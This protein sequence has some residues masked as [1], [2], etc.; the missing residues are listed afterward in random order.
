MQTTQENASQL[1]K[2]LDL[3]VPLQDIDAEVD[4]RLKKLSRTVKMQGF[5]PGKVPLKMVA[6]QYGGQVRQ[7]VLGEKVQKL[8]EDAV[9]EQQL[10]VA[11]YPRIEAKPS[12]EN[13]A[14]FEFTAT[15]EVYPEVA[16]G[17]LGAV[18]ITRPQVEVSEEAIDKTIEVLRK[19]QARYEPVDRAAAD[20]DKVDIDYRGLLEGADFQGGQDKG[21]QLIVGKG[22]ALPDFE[23]QLVGMKAGESKTFEATFPEDYHGKELAGKTVKFEVTLNRVEEQKLPEVNA[24]FANSLGVKDGS[25]ET[26]RKEIKE[27]LEREVKR[28][29]QDS[30]K[31][32]AMKALLE[33]TKLELPKA[34]VEMEANRLMQRM[35][36]DLAARG[37]Q[38]Q[39]IP[40]SPETH[41]ETARR[42][43]ALGLILAEVVKAQQ[44][45][46]EPEQVRE[47]VEEYAQAYEQPEEMVRWYYSNPERLAEAE[48]LVLEGKV[49]AWVLT[50]A[51]VVDK[52][53]A[54]DE[55]MGN[56]RA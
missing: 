42:R 13:A 7:E 12:Q 44:L 26:M 20:G 23:R 30:V 51:K 25:L 41:M 10:K 36:Q 28:R 2:R 1:E 24:D 31:E 43:V 56:A 38:V 53:T 29:V 50:Q 18:E 47:L 52:P 11:G 39:D 21:F 6:Q 17:D 5:R 9:Q 40:F 49:V 33:T 3:A 45:H 16:V 15:F 48:S 27:S 34:L 32:Q 4:I 14:H 37:L 19:Q 35:Q 46:A 22:H 54:F 55:L 8:F